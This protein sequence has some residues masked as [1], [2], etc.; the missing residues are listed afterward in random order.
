MPPQFCD[1]LEF[2]EDN[3]EIR[4]KKTK[5]VDGDR[6]TTSIQLKTAGVARRHPCPSEE[7]GGA[8]GG[9]STKMEQDAPGT[10]P[11]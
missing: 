7:H 10:S 5:G 4:I 6:H 9:S 3:G 8:V 1:F 11:R 2:W